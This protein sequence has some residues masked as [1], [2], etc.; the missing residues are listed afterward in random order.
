MLTVLTLRCSC[1]TNVTTQHCL[2]VQGDNNNNKVVFNKE[3]GNIK[4]KTIVYR[5]TL[6]LQRELGVPHRNKK[7]TL[8][9]KLRGIHSKIVK[10]TGMIG[11]TKLC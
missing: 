10:R 3:M 5:C 11:I 7:A 9:G 2:A 1:D 6:S 4:L 8:K